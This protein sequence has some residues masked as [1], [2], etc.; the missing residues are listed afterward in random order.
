MLSHERHIELLQ[1]MTPQSF[2]IQKDLKHRFV[3]W[4]LFVESLNYDPFGSYVQ[5]WRLISQYFIYA[6]LGFG[7]LL[8]DKTIA[9]NLAYHSPTKLDFR[10]VAHFTLGNTMT[11]LNRH[12]HADFDRFIIGYLEDFLKAKKTVI[13]EKNE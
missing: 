2:E 5:E 13:K 4:G 3:D 6:K 10:Q 1:H 7:R 11:N 8:R 9:L 12:I